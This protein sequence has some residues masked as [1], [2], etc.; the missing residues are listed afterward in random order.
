MKFDVAAIEKIAKIIILIPTI[1]VRFIFIFVMFSGLSG[2]NVYIEGN[3]PI[4]SLLL[5]IG[6]LM[7]TCVSVHELLELTMKLKNKGSSLI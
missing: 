1:I 7:I 2:K 6:I 4:I 3:Y 5:N